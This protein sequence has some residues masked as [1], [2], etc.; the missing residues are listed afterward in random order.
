MTH[1]EFPQLKMINWF[2]WSKYEIEI[3]D[4]VDWRASGTPAVAAAFADD[5]PDWLRFGK[6]VTVCTKL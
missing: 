2:E 3:A 1:R 4:D 6:D 5:L